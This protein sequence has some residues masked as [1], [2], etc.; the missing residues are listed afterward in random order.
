MRLPNENDIVNCVHR[1]ASEH[2]SGLFGRILI[3]FHLLSQCFFFL[4]I[5]FFFFESRWFVSEYIVPFKRLSDYDPDH[6]NICFADE[7]KKNACVVLFSLP[8]TC[9]LQFDIFLSRSK[10]DPRFEF[11]Y[12]SMHIAYMHTLMWTFKMCTAV[13]NLKSD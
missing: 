4:F 11:Q 5:F 7:L 3:F 8:L 6:G 1:H 10:F 12:T 13:H 2:S 9:P